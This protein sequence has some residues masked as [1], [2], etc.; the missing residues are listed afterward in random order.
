[1]AA[2][3]FLSFFRF[4]QWT[5]VRR[6]RRGFLHAFQLKVEPYAVRLDNTAAN[7]IKFRCSSGVT[8]EERGGPFGDYGQWSDICPRGVI[9]G[10]Q[11]KVQP[12]QGAFKD[13]T[14]LND[15]IFFCCDLS[16][17]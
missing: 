1:M 9:C 3:T 12:Y 7:S 13:D 2:Y 8:L 6:C 11:T 17:P 10:M 14:S 16:F 5:P 4:G 15:V